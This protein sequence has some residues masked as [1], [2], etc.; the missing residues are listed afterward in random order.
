MRSTKNKKSLEDVTSTAELAKR[1]NLSR[2]TVSRVLNGH[3]GV[4]PKTVARIRA[5]MSEYGFAPNALAQGL[6]TGR[7]NIIGV[8]LPE[9]EGL[10]LGQKLEF[11]REALT[12]KGYHVMVGMTNGDAQEELATVSRF[13]DLR[14]AGVILVASRVSQT[15]V[16]I[17]SFLKSRTPLIQ[18]DPMIEPPAGSICVDR[19]KGMRQATQHLLELGHRHIVPLGFSK[20]C[21]YSLQRLEGVIAAYKEKGLDSDKYVHPFYFPSD[22]GSFYEWGRDIAAT[23]WKY[24][25]GTQRN[26]ANPTAV[27]ALND[28]LAIGFIDGLRQLGVRVPEDFSVIGYDNMEIGAFIAPQLTSI[29]AQPDELIREATERLLQ[30]IR[31]EAAADENV[32]SIPARLLC[33]GSTGPRK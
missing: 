22:A 23:I 29:D 30:R 1:L 21:R 15:S 4:H 16:S 26:P 28:R 18:L 20:D 24:S 33:R 27:L 6:K 32:V 7:T 10:Y 9:I 11:L 25:C 3:S 17:Q 13:R 12:A 8:C 2:W 14:A 31:G 19:A 5:A